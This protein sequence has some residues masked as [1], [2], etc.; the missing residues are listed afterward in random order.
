M[1]ITTPEINKSAIPNVPQT[2]P[3]TASF[4]VEIVSNIA[5]PPRIF[6]KKAA[7]PHSASCFATCELT[8]LSDAISYCKKSS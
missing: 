4:T 1:V 5:S 2:T 8:R 6:I 3:P 7:S